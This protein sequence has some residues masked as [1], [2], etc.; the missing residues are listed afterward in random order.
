MASIN[1]PNTNLD[2]TVRI[3]DNFYRFQADIPAAEYDVVFS[4]FQSVM[5]TRQAAENFTVSL[6]QVASE[7]GQEPLTLLSQFQGQTGVNLD[8][9]LAYYLNQIRSRAALLGVGAPVKPNFYAAR[10]VIQ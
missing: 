3:F 4:Y 2:Q 9:T 6:F 8:T 1:E 5:G 10:N 7:S